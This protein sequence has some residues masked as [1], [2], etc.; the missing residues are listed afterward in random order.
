MEEKLENL[1]WKAE[2]FL[3]LRKFDKA[4]FTSYLALSKISENRKVTSTEIT[5]NQKLFENLNLLFH[6]CSS[7]ASCDCVPFMAIVIQSLLE[8]QRE[9]ENQINQIGLLQNFYG[10]IPKIPY[11]ILFLSVNG[12]VIIGKY[13]Q[14][15]EVLSFCLKSNN[16]SFGSSKLFNEEQYEYLVQVYI[17]YVLPELKKVE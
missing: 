8:I 2:N 3:V 9:N 5:D 10:S 1:L 7:K 17:F 13:E 11:K 6:S 14:A 12:L 16:Q 4:L 15:Y